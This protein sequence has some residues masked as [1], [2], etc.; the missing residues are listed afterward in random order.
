[1]FEILIKKKGPRYFIFSFCF[2]FNVFGQENGVKHGWILL[3]EALIALLLFYVFKQKL[4]AIM[5]FQGKT[6]ISDKNVEKG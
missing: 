1:M 2:F 5:V 6:I 3:I 4:P